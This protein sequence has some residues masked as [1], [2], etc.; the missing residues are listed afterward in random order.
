MTRWSV[1]DINEVL[2]NYHSSAF[3]GTID[4]FSDN[5][6]LILAGLFIRNYFKQRQAA[7]AAAS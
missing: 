4:S 1:S 3:K 7:A 2:I 6:V 5:A